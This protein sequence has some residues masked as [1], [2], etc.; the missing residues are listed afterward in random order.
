MAEEGLLLGVVS[1]ER[2]K[3][4]SNGLL[5]QRLVHVDIF[6]DDAA[7]FVFGDLVGE[8]VLEVGIR[9]EQGCNTLTLNGG[10]HLDL[11]L[12]VGDGGKGQKTGNE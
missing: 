9:L 6:I 12:G 2:K 4:G 7:K 5:D 8:V 11:L 3:R 1:V 10:G